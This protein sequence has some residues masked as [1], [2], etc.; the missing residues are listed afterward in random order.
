M[1]IKKV[2]FALENGKVFFY[3]PDGSHLKD[4]KLENFILNKY[5][6]YKNVIGEVEIKKEKNKILWGIK[7][8]IV[9]DLIS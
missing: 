2:A 7:N 9:K 6:K 1:M 4:E 8:I 5:K 3:N